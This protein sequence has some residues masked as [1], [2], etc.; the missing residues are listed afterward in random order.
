MEWSYNVLA[1]RNFITN[2]ATSSAAKLA[3]HCALVYENCIHVRYELVSTPYQ[4][5]EEGGSE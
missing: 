5:S 1:Q 2:A 4:Q 3:R